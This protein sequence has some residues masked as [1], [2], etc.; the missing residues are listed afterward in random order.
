MLCSTKKYERVIYER[1]R[2]LA[3]ACYSLWLRTE[4][5]YRH[6]LDDLICSTISFI[7]STSFYLNVFSLHGP[8]TR[9]LQ[10]N[11]TIPME[12]GKFAPYQCEST[13]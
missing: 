7:P 5:F 1:V 11:V 10:R 8:P 9:D 12:Q 6:L 13:K 4:F 2:A 3:L